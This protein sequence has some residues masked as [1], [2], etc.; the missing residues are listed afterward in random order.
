MFRYFFHRGRHQ[1]RHYHDHFFGL[2]QP[3]FLRSS[4]I[5]AFSCSLQQHQFVDS[6]YSLREG[7]EARA[8]DASQQTSVLILVHFL[9][10]DVFIL[11]KLLSFV[12]QREGRGCCIG[13]PRDLHVDAASTYAPSCIPCASSL[14]SFCSSVCVEGVL[15]EAF[16]HAFRGHLAAVPSLST[17]GCTGSHLANQIQLSL[18]FD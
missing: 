8:R 16:G 7:D 14:Y 10:Y 9:A 3:G 1:R 15:C 5:V 2:D 4:M 13:S 12:C 11:R 17:T 18:V 6:P